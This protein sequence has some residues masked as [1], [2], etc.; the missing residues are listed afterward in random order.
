VDGRSIL[1][2]DGA[3]RFVQSEKS[4]SIQLTVIRDGK[5]SSFVLKAP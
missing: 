2:E 5:R 1:V 4:R 3:L